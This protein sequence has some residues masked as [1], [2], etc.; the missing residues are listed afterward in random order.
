MHKCPICG[1]KVEEV[2]AKCPKCGFQIVLSDKAKANIKDINEIPNLPFHLSN[3]DRL[4]FPE[5]FFFVISLVF[6]LFCGVVGMIISIAPI[7]ICAEVNASFSVIA[8]FVLA[9]IGVIAT[10]IVVSYR[11]WLV[12]E[13]VLTKPSNKI[14]HIL[15]D[16]Q[17]DSYLDLSGGLTGDAVYWRYPDKSYKKPF[18]IRLFF[19]HLPIWLC[20][21]LVPLFI[22]IPVAVGC[23]LFFLLIGSTLLF[24]LNIREIIYV[25]RFVKNYIC[26]KCGAEMKRK[27]LSSSS[28]ESITKKGGNARTGNAKVGE[29]EFEDGSRGDVYSQ[30]TYYTPVRTYREKHNHET[31]TIVCPKCNYSTGKTHEEHEGYRI[32]ID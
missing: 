20:A 27:T 9:V 17:G 28:S 10:A 19:L 2:E 30:Y 8:Y 12:K 15:E 3:T 23:L 1:E 31:F 22:D 29:V 32:R 14:I 11:V 16:S 6:M 18:W 13:R 26:P 21:V 5:K 7:V 24:T 25:D 4:I